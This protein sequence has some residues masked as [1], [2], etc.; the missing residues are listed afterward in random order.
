VP[1]ELQNE[2]IMQALITK[3]KTIQSGAV[4]HNTIGDENITQY[5]HTLEEMQSATMPFLQVIMGDTDY[6]HLVQQHRDQ[7]EMPVTIIGI[8][9]SDKREEL[10]TLNRRLIRDVLLATLSD[11]TLGATCHT[12]HVKTLATDE[13]M[14][15]YQDHAMFEL[16]LLIGFH[17]SWSDP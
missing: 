4:Y 10:A 1:N 17:M 11:V 2:T 8:V 7:V 12:V 16:S 15:A 3:L 14:L 9:K 6:D 5:V 13:G